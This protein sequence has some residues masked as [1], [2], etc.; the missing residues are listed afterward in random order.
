MRRCSFFS[1]LPLAILATWLSTPGHSEDAGHADFLQQLLE[2]KIAQCKTCHGVE[3]QG[4]Y[5][6]VPI[7]RLAGQQARYFENQLNAFIE[8][9]RTNKYMYS[10]EHV[11][12]PAMRAA[13]AGYFSGLS[14]KSVGGGARKE[15]VVIG[16]KIFEDGLPDRVRP[17]ASCHGL[18]AKGDGENPRLAGQLHDYIFNKLKNWTKERGLDSNHPDTSAIMQP[19]AHSLTEAQI[20]AVAAYLNSIE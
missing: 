5:G 17:C 20:D 4:S 11:L 7:P 13:L 10:A 14:A 18:D 12:R 8:G 19:I 6:V 15:L 16:K 9:R 3:G 2:A 1:A